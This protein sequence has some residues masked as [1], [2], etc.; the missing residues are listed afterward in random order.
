MDGGYNLEL[1]GLY[2]RLRED[3][4]EILTKTNSE[5]RN[6]MKSMVLTAVFSLVLSLSIISCDGNKP[7]V[8]NAP[9]KNDMAFTY[10]ETITYKGR[11]LSKTTSFKFEKAGDNLF[12]C[13]R[14]ITD[15]NGS[16]EQESLQVD[17]FFMYN[18]VMDM[19]VS[20]YPLWRNPKDLASG[21]I[22]TMKVIEGTHNGKSV[23][24]TIQSDNERA[25]YAMDTGFLEGAHIDLGDKSQTVVRID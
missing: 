12:T 5:R 19:L 9:L 2:L 1:L 23:Y 8:K 15:K 17:G 20:S 10:N 3:Y 7:N 25:H 21:N 11:S 18:E 22:G 6:A 24:T 13:H 4:Y 14:T 16:Q